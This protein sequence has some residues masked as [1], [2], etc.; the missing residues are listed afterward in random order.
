MSFYDQAIAVL[1]S[2]RPSDIA[3]FQTKYAAGKAKILA[4]DHLFRLMSVEES[5]KWTL[6]SPPGTKEMSPSLMPKIFEGGGGYTSKWFTFER[7]YVFTRQKINE[8]GGREGQGFLMTIIL[9]HE[10]KNTLIK[11]LL[12]DV[13]L[14]GFSEE[15]K[16]N[17][18]RCKV[19]GGTVTL[20]ISL[21]VLEKM[22]INMEIEHLGGRV[23]PF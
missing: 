19:E 13:S 9:G 18:C 7:P 1:K 20:G 22:A 2:T 5:K 14:N 3:D 21:P 4:S 10:M 15:L 17:S 16:A 11:K 12:P 8:P 23:T 6:V